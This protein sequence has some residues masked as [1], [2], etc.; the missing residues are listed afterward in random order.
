MSPYTWD[1]LCLLKYSN[2]CIPLQ[3]SQIQKIDNVRS[4][5]YMILNVSGAK[6]KV[7]WENNDY[8][9][10][11]PSLCVTKPWDMIKPCR[12]IGS[13]L[14]TRDHHSD[15]RHPIFIIKVQTLAHVSLN[16]LS[17]TKVKQLPKYSLS[18]YQSVH[19]IFNVYLCIKNV[20]RYDLWYVV[21]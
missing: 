6:S 7:F 14:F 9:A 15:P 12:I 2:I 5:N 17:T 10:D 20:Q 21:I 19:K 8:P 3:M 16:L 4:P 18:T 11:A 13:F 1:I